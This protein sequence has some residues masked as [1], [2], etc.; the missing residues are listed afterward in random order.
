MSEKNP[1]HVGYE[2]ITLS[3]T[4]ALLN[5]LV[6]SALGSSTWLIRLVNR[7]FFCWCCSYL[8]A[9]ISILLPHLFPGRACCLHHPYY[10]S[11]P[12]ILW[13]GNHS[14]WRST[15]CSFV[16]RHAVQSPNFRH[17]LNYSPWFGPNRPSYLGPF[18][19][20]VTAGPLACPPYLTGSLAGDYGFDPLRLG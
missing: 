8:V 19:S 5:F 9:K 13:G 2:I 3:K 6:P 18:S 14:S 7:K 10:R 4:R 1:E 17:L 15:P 12:R 11:L 20:I 16:G